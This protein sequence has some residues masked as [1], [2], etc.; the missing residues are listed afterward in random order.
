M[1]VVGHLTEMRSVLFVFFDKRGRL[2]PAT[3]TSAIPGASLSDVFAALAGHTQAVLEPPSGSHVPVRGLT[4]VDGRAPADLPPG[5]VGLAIG[6]GR[7][8]LRNVLAAAVRGGA[9]CV[10]VAGFSTEELVAVAPTGGHHV[11][12]ISVLRST[13]WDLVRDLVAAVLASAADLPPADE[14][15]L[16]SLARTLL[17]ITGGSVSIEDNSHR[18]LAYAAVPGEV[19]EL[20]L[21]SILNREGPENFLQ[22][23]RERGVYERLKRPGAVVRIGADADLGWSARI[24]TGIFTG[25]QQLGTVWLQEG[26]SKLAADAGVS[27]IAASRLAAHELDR[28]RVRARPRADV[29]R[30][31]LTERVDAAVASMELRIPTAQQV[32]LMGV[33]LPARSDDPPEA[34]A[35]WRARLTGRLALWAA[36]ER[37]EAVTTSLGGV[38]Y[39]LLPGE[40][41]S[42]LRSLTRIVDTLAADMRLE[43]AAGISGVGTMSEVAL[44]RNQV[45]SSRAISLSAGQRTTH[46]EEVCSRIALDD[47]LRQVGTQGL[48]MQAGIDRLFTADGRWT[49]QATTLLSFF[50][51]QGD[52]G[53]VSEYLH[54]HPNTV[55][56]RVRRAAGIAGVRLD[57]PDDRLLAHL[58]L[59]QRRR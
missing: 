23:L 46:Y 51:R 11:A 38:V 22:I 37:K 19:D 35:D 25:E 59:R 8:G 58:A 15:A 4:L 39:L 43:L 55:R 41:A 50:E 7:S 26:R 6:A 29:L 16:F 12:L 30:D 28:E 44:L 14:G 53:Q 5:Y 57:D 3:R 33:E 17:T 45:E 36:S 10:V 13:P 49:D 56:Y 48:L 1:R 40:P 21:H 31:A 52:V 32:R 47:L 2:M 24:A 20:R 18:V 9:A 54:V 27:L 34:D 42:S